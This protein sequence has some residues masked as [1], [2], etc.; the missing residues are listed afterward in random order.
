MK[1]CLKWVIFKRLVESYVTWCYSW[2]RHFQSIQASI[3]EESKDY[4][5][6]KAGGGSLLDYKFTIFVLWKECCA[7]FRESK[8]RSPI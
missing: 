1:F 3:V 7:R 8:S 6:K 2:F 4:I 5:N